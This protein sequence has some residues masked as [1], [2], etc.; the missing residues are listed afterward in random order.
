M[1]NFW[2]KIKNLFGS[3]DVDKLQQSV[4]SENS[5]VNYTGDESNFDSGA[6]T[7]QMNHKEK[8]EENENC[9]FYGLKG[10][11]DGRGF[12]YLW[13]KDNGVVYDDNNDIENV[14]EVIAGDKKGK[15]IIF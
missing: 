14:Y 12:K 11:L 15:K 7:C 6:Q 13:S 4:D 10:N 8:E 9:L 2:Q 3:K 1:A 5:D